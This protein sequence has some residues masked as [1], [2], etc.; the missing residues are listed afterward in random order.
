[1]VKYKQ[2][3]IILLS[4]QKVSALFNI[5]INLESFNNN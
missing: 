5:S 4:E 1:M 3:F 2:E